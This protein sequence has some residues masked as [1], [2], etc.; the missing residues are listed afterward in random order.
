MQAVLQI[1]GFRR[2]WLSMAISTLGSGLTTFALP[3]LVYQTTGSVLLTGMVGVAQLGPYV[4]FGLVAGAVADRWD[5]RRLMV[6]SNLVSA[7]AIGLIPLLQST[8]P[9]T[10]ALILGAAF[11]S[12][13]AVV[14]L[15]AATF[16]A[17][18]TLVPRAQLG[19]ANSLLAST[20]T[21]LSVAAPA[22][23]GLLAS[24]W[25]FAPLFVLD[26]LTFMLAALILVTI[27]QPFQ[28]PS[29]P[30]PFSLRELREN[31][32][33]GLVY[34]GGHRLIR[35]LT[36]AGTGNALA[37]GALGALLVVYAVR[38]LGL[39]TTDP[40]IGL[41]FGVGAAGSF[42]GSILLPFMT[43]TVGP[44]RFTTYALTAT[45][46]LLLLL[47]QVRAVVLVGICYAAW[48]F[49]YS[50]IVINGITI[51]QQIV[52]DHLQSRVNTAARLL[53]LG[54]VPVGSALAGVIASVLPVPLALSLFALV[55]GGSAAL[56]WSAGLQR[57]RLEEQ[58]EEA[59]AANG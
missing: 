5:R 38:Y 53:A 32:R 34:L 57:Y 20:S 11:V 26:S 59:V 21:A 41:L 4:L 33:E 50:A 45:P 28:A 56:A 24:I 46:W 23:G 43:R 39:E 13:T 14:C 19:E 18:A 31:I 42:L 25:G 48:R 2:Y 9:A 16:G 3:L 22:L 7:L 8:W 47:V 54:G 30:R 15:D 6:A 17:V 58:P 35:T 51:R 37:G 1:P 10:V 49:L 52:P 27:R 36:F 40:A 12:A 44:G 55:L 29:T